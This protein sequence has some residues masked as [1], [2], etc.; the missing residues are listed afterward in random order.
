MSN[1]ITKEFIFNNTNIR[2]EMHEGQL[3]WSVVDI[4]ESL[5][6]SPIPRNY[7][8]DLKNGHSITGIQLHGKIVQLKMKATDGKMRE[9]D[10]ATQE[11]IF[12]II[13]YIPSKKA[14]PFKE[15][16][17]KIANQ[18]FEEE[19]NPQLA[20]DRA[21]RTWQRH[22]RSDEWIAKRLKGIAVR[23]TTTDTWKAHG[24]EGKQYGALTNI[25]HVGVFNKTVKQHTEELAVSGNL[26]DNLDDLELL[27]LEFAE[28]ASTK[29]TKHRN[30]QGYDEVK[31]DVKEGSAI[32]ADALSKYK[33]LLSEQ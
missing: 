15:L 11:N 2:S 27:A 9:T 31:K 3:Y 21:V 7:W 23:N 33:K 18:R 4:V 1:I 22:G 17:A 24:I 19:K 5:E 25:L 28:L 14:D 10:C 13:Q 6:V 20:V 32:G 16:F 12:Y 8:S 30:S 26:R 29:L